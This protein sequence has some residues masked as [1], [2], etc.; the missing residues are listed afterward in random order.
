[1]F[2]PRAGRTIPGEQLRAT[3]KIYNSDSS[4]SRLRFPETESAIRNASLGRLSD[5]EALKSLLSDEGRSRLAPAR[6]Q[7]SYETRRTLPTGGQE[8]PKH[9]QPRPQP[10]PPLLRSALCRHRGEYGTAHGRV[11]RDPLVYPPNHFLLIGSTL[12]LFRE[13]FVAACFWG[14][15]RKGICY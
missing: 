1:M 5:E 12:A 11:D 3:C 9:P 15:N 4:T 8:L 14:P 6:R 13:A 10:G 2:H 7:G